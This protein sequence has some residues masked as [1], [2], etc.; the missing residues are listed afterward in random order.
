MLLARKVVYMKKHIVKI[1]AIL[2]LIIAV[3]IMLFLMN[4][5]NHDLV[6]VQ[7][8][9]RYEENDNIIIEYP[10]ITGSSDKIDYQKIN[11]LIASSS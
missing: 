6:M 2:G 11:A 8:S 1:I 3:I 10:I 5:K 4:A 7:D 9:D